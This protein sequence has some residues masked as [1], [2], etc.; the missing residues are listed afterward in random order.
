MSGSTEHP[1]VFI[2]YSWS[3]PEHE[4]FVLE[5]ATTLR[6]HGVDAVLDKWDLKPGQDKY[7]FM[8]AMVTDSAVSKVLVLCDKRYQEKADIRIGGVGT[9]SQIISQ[10]LYKKVQQTKFIP[11]VCEYNE[12][13]PCLP[14]FMKCRIFVDL[15]SEERYGDGL[16]Q[17]LRLIYEQPFHQ[18]P[19]LGSPP[20]FLKSVSGGAYVKELS[21]ALRAIQ[22]GKP[23]RQGLE[24]LFVKGL[25]T[26][27]IRLY[28]TPTGDDY[29]EAIYQAIQ[30]TKE[31]RDQLSEYVETVA[32]FSGDE[33]DALT[34]FLRL[35]EGLG[36]M[37]GPPDRDGMY[38]TGWGDL[39]TFF[40]L[41]AFL[42]ATAA[43]I[44]HERWKSL[45][46]LLSYSYVTRRSNR[47]MEAVN[48]VAFDNFQESIDQH[49]NRRLQLNRTCVTADMLK[50]RCSKERTPF[51]ELLQA[52][53]FLALDSALH[54]K[55]RQGTSFV[56][57]WVPRT[58]VYTSD[59]RKLPLFM[60][61][62]NEDIR[63]GIRTA[64]GVKSGA[65]LTTRIEE[66]RVLLNNF[67]ALSIDRW[68][69]FN[70][71]ETINLAILTKQ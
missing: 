9:E 8:E 34:P 14:V 23:N 18:K 39:Y 4:Q 13:E 35:M 22:D 51:P 53:V 63:A 37:F 65:E 19:R 15:S 40:A 24:H 5:L 20:S 32:A 17:L 70:L 47:E 61:A 28:V 45:R 6:N 46:R 68:N 16:D 59:S 52:D 48:Y 36:E 56:S 29:D 1:K 30:N 31:L 69:R 44:R 64:L 50:E 27:I 12:E 33:P 38:M 43:L 41:E 10:E 3:G 71:I 2:S 25:L 62:V 21:A 66:G 55:E 54:A 60:R 11:V 58:T 49:R 42:L 57:S 7:V 67:Q 26:E